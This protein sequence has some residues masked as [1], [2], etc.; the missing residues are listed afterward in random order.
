MCW[1]GASITCTPPPNSPARALMELD[2]DVLH[3]VVMG[4]S[5]DVRWKINCTPTLPPSTDTFFAVACPVSAARAFLGYPGAI[6]LLRVFSDTVEC[7]Y[8]VSF[9]MLSFW[10]QYYSSGFWYKAIGSFCKT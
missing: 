5:C 4:S 6:A 8:W 7:T 10:H 2:R 9:A 1:R 3:V